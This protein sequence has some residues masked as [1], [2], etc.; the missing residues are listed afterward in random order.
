[1]G[2]ASS[3]AVILLLGWHR[4][5]DPGVTKRHDAKHLWDDEPSWTP[6]EPSEELWI[7]R[8][9]RWLRM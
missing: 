5:R 2:A 6:E 3:F 7:S 4:R 9:W 8:L 1:M